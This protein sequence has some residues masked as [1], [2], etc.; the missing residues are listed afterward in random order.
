[1]NLLG[2]VIPSLF[3]GAVKGFLGNVWGDTVNSLKKNGKK[4]IYDVI[5]A[6]RASSNK[7]FKP[8]A[9]DEDEQLDNEQDNNGME[10]EGGDDDGYEPIVAPRRN[11]RKSVNTR[12]RVFR[13]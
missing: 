13:R 10:E 7:R 2:A 5:G 8:M 6:P 4:A 12:K 9:G 11:R 3:S 1:M